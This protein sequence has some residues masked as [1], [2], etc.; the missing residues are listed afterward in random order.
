MILASAGIRFGYFELSVVPSS[1]MDNEMMIGG[2]QLGSLVWKSEYF[3]PTTFRQYLKS[4]LSSKGRLAIRASKVCNDFFQ[5]SYGPS[6]PPQS[7]PL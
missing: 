6:S 4:P 7:S 2:S 3:S 5:E 1:D